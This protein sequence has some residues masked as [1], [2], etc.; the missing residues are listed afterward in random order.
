[1]QFKLNDDVIEDIDRLQSTAE[2][3]NEGYAKATMD[4]LV[5]V[6]TAQKYV[7]QDADIKKLLD[8]YYTMVKNDVSKMK[9]TLRNLKEVDTKKSAD[10]KKGDSGK[11]VCKQKVTSGTTSKDIKR[12][13]DTVNKNATP[14]TSGSSFAGGGG[15]AGGGGGIR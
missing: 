6:E 13:S 9:K 2:K 12:T 3:F 10:Y 11:C 15:V 7:T 5:N 1:M 8:T 14:K 4:S